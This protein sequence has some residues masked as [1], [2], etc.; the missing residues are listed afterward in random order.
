MQIFAGVRE[1]WGVK[2]ESGRLRCRFSYLSLAIFSE[3]SSPRRDKLTQCCCAFIL[4]L[5]RL[6]C[7]YNYST[8]TTRLQEFLRGIR[9]P[10]YKL[11]RRCRC[12]DSNKSKSTN[13]PCASSTYSPFSEVQYIVVIWRSRNGGERINKVTL[14]YVTARFSSGGHQPI[15]HRHATSY[16]GQL[17]LLSSAG[18][19]MSSATMLRGWGVEATRSHP[20]FVGNMSRVTLNS[21]LSKIPFVHFK[22][23]SRPTLTPEI[24]HV[25]L[26]V[27]I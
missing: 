14:M 22:P 6:S 12:H 8:N 17:S 5:A 26:L 3:S 2:Q 16:P 1:I 11:Y 23:G 7:F 24:K 4:A 10:A 9:S 13:L 19:E 25:H 20:E 27:L 21:D 18:R 15:P